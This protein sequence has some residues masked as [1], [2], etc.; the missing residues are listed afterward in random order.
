MAIQQIVERRVIG[1][2][3]FVLRLTTCGK[4]NCGRCPHG[5]YWYR[6]MKSRRGRP[7]LKYIGKELPK[8]AVLETTSD[9]CDTDAGLIS[10]SLPS[11]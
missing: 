7:F 1:Q 11:W 4:P 9:A 2:A 3:V 8:W 10:D 5:P 6:L